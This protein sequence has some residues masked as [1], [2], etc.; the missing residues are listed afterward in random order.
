MSNQHSIEMESERNGWLGPLHSV[1]VPD[2]VTPG[3]W[4]ILHRNLDRSPEKRLLLAI[5]EDAIN[6]WLQDGL[7]GRKARLRG[8]A[9][10][11]L[12]GADDGLFGFRSVC[13]HLEIDPAYFRGRLRRSQ[14]QAAP[15]RCRRSHS[16]R[17]ASVSAIRER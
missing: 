10:Q 11:W 4:Q 15:R 7:T 6:C 12:F 2:L 9:E 5:L 3:Q 16:G 17:R 8:E 13:E 1:A 14:G